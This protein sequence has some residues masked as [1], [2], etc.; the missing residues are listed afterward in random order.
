MVLPP[1][2]SDQNSRFRP[3]GP[4]IRKSRSS[5]KV[6]CSV[7]KPILIFVTLSQTVVAT[8]TERETVALSRIVS[9]PEPSLTKNE[10]VGMRTSPVD[11]RAD[12][13]TAAATSG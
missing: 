7:V 13:R 9:T 12:S 5:E 11:A 2:A 1:P 4:T 3:S 10:P 6:C 8:P